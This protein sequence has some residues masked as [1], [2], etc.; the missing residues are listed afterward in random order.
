MARKSL[1][2]L[3]RSELLGIGADEEAA[4]LLSTDTWRDVWLADRGFTPGTKS[5]YYKWARRYLRWVV[6]NGGHPEALRAGA[7][8]DAAV[9]AFLD[10]AEVKTNTVRSALGAL[11]LFIDWLGIGPLSVEP[12][13]HERVAKRVLSDEEMRAARD[14]ARARTP[15]DHALISFCL[16]VGP[17]AGELRALDVADLELGAQPRVRVTDSSG[18]LRVVPLS[19]SLAWV[20]EGWLRVR[21]DMLGDDRDKVTAL[22]VTLSSRARIHDAQ[23][24]E[25]IVAEIGAAA[26]LTFRLTPATVRDT[27]EAN[28]IRDNV[29]AAVR[30]QRMGRSNAKAAARREQVLR[31][32][33]VSPTANGSGAANDAVD[34]AVVQSAPRGRDITGQIALDL[35]Q[36]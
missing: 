32:G 24:V 16:E 23:S 9:V 22:F 35:G 13:R 30:A 2:S 11:R 20:L 27:A 5:V 15:R 7:S 17:T 10:S 18:G 33:Q 1:I 25:Y 19:T 6:T 8:R 31:G 14:A 28:L 3:N 21:A 36:G 34:T 12:P 26:G 4:A 29:P